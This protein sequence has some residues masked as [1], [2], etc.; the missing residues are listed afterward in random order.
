MFVFIISWAGQHHNA[1]LI[2]NS[3]LNVYSNVTIIF[4]DPD[5]NFTLNNKYTFIRRSN[6][7]FWS[8][9]F[10]ACLDA[11]KNDD[12][13]VI[14]ADCSSVDWALLVLRCIEVTKQYKQIGVWCPKINGTPFDLRFSG[15]MKLGNSGIIASA[16]T[17]G[18]VFY[19]SLPIINRMRNV[20]YE[21]NLYGWAIDCLFCSAS[22]VFNKIVVIDTKIEVIH[23]SSKRG[24]S[25]KLAKIQSDIFMNQFT[26]NELIKFQLLKSFV[27]SNRSKYQ[28]QINNGRSAPS[29]NDL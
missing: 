16:L 3:I 25:S 7:L 8:D 24:Y 12:M 10:K 17:D 22:H 15:I 23:P 27:N 20:N 4:S 21:N 13:L 19:L 2:A 14:H 26:I 28:I 1:Q 29:I 11:T 6:D 5:P 18:I 9:K